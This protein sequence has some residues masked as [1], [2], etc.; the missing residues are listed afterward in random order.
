ME[1]LYS[2]FINT[3][4]PFLGVFLIFY[5]LLILPEKKR[6]KTFQNMLDELKLHDEVVTKGGIVGKIS[7]IDDK[8]I[9]I[10]TSSAKTRIKL[11]KNGVSYKVK[12]D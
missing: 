6:K 3:V 7:H 5:F 12:L 8:Y 11:E 10:E 9:T 2:M 4:L 1:N